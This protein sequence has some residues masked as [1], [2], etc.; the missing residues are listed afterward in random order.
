M[1][2]PR[3]YIFFIA[4][5]II[6]FLESLVFVLLLTRYR[7]LEKELYEILDSRKK[8]LELMDE[9]EFRIKKKILLAQ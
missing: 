8:Y 2:T 4:T 3:I 6:I 7:R 5:L 1:K 9:I